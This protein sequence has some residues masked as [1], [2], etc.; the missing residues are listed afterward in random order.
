MMDF[1]F[2]F[3][4]SN[5]QNRHETAAAKVHDTYESLNPVAAGSCFFKSENNE[6]KITT[7]V[8]HFL[9]NVNPFMMSLCII[10]FFWGGGITSWK[11][12]SRRCYTVLPQVRP[13]DATGL[14]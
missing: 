9:I 3:Q 13:V 2:F 6:E 4:G 5:Y 8:N 1:F 11:T 12:L 10:I 14:I 7:R